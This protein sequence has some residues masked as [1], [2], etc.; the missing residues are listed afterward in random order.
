MAAGAPM[1]VLRVTVAVQLGDQPPIVMQQRMERPDSDGSP[2][3][4]RAV[5]Q[6]VAEQGTYAL[7]RTGRLLG[8]T[9]DQVL[10]VELTVHDRVELDN[11]QNG[12]QTA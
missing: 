4:Y 6:V 11:T 2:D 12:T 9:F 7:A 3:L 8:L 1:A 5:A 10:E